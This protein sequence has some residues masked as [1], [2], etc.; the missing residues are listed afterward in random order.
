MKSRT[1]ELAASAL[2][3][4]AVLFLA[5]CTRQSA[6][7]AGPM[8]LTDASAG[9]SLALPDT[10][11]AGLAVRPAD[12][13]VWSVGYAP[14][15]TLVY[16]RVLDAGAAF[17]PLS[18]R[19]DVIDKILHSEF[20]DTLVVFSEDAQAPDGSDVEL[21]AGFDRD[22]NGV[23]GFAW[24][25]GKTTM[26][27]FLLSGPDIKADREAAGAV[28]AE[29]W[30]RLSLSPRDWG[31]ERMEKS[32]IR[33][34]PA[35]QE[36]GNDENENIDAAYSLFSM[37]AHDP[38]NYR[39]AVIRVCATLMRMDRRGGADPDVRTRALSALDSFLDILCR[40]QLAARERFLH[41][42]G[43]RDR[44]AAA[45]AARLLDAFDSPYDPDAK[46][47]SDARWA[48]VKEI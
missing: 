35:F 3:A 42:V 4:A 17:L 7:P 9:I 41:A 43:R 23:A 30:P 37:R 47:R 11:A 39:E 20:R 6:V 44:A 27:V 32:R 45:D 38:D 26:A 24:Q 48:R 16:F 1:F 31:V 5:G 18:L 34:N 10:A 19:G 46:S 2:L 13:Y 28:L 29:L 14:N 25:G 15:R 22:N 40:D 8:R 36:D 21:L 33:W 12:R